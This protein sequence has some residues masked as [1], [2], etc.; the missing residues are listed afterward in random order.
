MCNDETKLRGKIRY[1][2]DLLIR[3]K[4]PREQERLSS[5]LMALRITLQKMQYEKQNKYG[6]LF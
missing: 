3:S 2:E 6:A 5:S 4:D 1:L